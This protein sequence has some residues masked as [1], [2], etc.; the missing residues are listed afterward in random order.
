MNNE[1]GKKESVFHQPVMVDE[2]IHYLMTEQLNSKIPSL[3]IDATVGGGGHTQ[4]ILEHLPEKNSIVIG[5]DCDLE[6]INYTKNRLKNYSNLYLFKMNYIKINEVVQKFPQYSVQGVLFDFGASYHQLT[7]GQRGFSYKENGPLDMRFDQNLRPTA[8]DIIQNSSPQALKKIFKEF[9]EERFA[10]K[11]AQEVYRNRDRINTTYDLVEIIQQII[12]SYKIKKTFA[13]I[14]Q[15]LRIAVNQELEN[16]QH[17][18][19]CAIKILSDGGRIVTIAYHSLE[20]RIVKNTFRTLAQNHQ[21]FRLKV[22][23]K[24]PVRPTLKEIK[25]N[26][27]AHSARLRAAE[28]QEYYQ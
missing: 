1:I 12:P 5:L 20:D 28:K 2:V 9:G 21:E 3:Y 8:K 24:K 19:N 27:A 4:A 14:F 22:L 10:H 23:T 18:L 13:R 26:P 7:S 16:I 15:A 11:I 6:A 25:F 17:G